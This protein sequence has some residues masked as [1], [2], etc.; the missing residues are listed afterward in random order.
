MGRI[1]PTS[2]LR[3][4]TAVATEISYNHDEDEENKYR[5][6]IEFISRKQWTREVDI[7]LMDLQP[8]STTEKNH[9]DLESESDVA[10]KAGAKIQAV[11]P[12]MT[13]R[14]LAGCTSA[15]LVDHSNVVNLLGTT[16]TLRCPTSQKLREKIEVYIDSKDKDEEIG[17]FW[18]IVK[19]VRI[20]AK[21]EVLANG[22]TIVDLVCQALYERPS[23]IRKGTDIW[24]DSLA[25]K[26]GMRPELQSPRTT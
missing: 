4:C 13:L 14:D 15:Q 20:F 8:D 26:I 10:K 19:V 17:A 3:A 16:I 12:S 25:T 5:A 24:F 2:C 22:V 1:L 18:P 9:L 7:L 11:F 23:A 6:E 21:A